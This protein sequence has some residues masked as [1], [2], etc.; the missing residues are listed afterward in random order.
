MPRAFLS[1]ADMTADR[2]LNVAAPKASTDGINRAWALGPFNTE[3]AA[4]GGAMR[5][6]Y[7]PVPIGVDTAYSAFP[8]VVQLPDGTLRMVYRQG[9]D[10]VATHDG[11]IK[12]CTSPDLGRTW[13]A[14]TTIE[15]DGTAPDVRDPS[16]SISPDGTKV[17]FTYFKENSSSVGIGMFFRLSTDG[18]ATYGSEV[19]MDASLVGGAITSPVVDPGTGTL[20]AVGYAKSGVETNYSTWLFTSTN[21]GTTWANARV[22]NGATDVRD[23]SEPWL[24]WTGGTNFTLAHRYGTAG[25][26]LR[27]STN[28]G[29]SWTAIAQIFAAYSGRPSLVK[30]ST[31]SLYM[32]LRLISDGSGWFAYSRDSGA[33]WYPPKRISLGPNN[34][35]AQTYACPIEISYGVAFVPTGLE[36]AYTSSL[37]RI[38]GLYI[39]DGPAMDPLGG[40]NPPTKLAIQDETDLIL[41]AD[42]FQRPDGAIGNPWQMLAGAVLISGGLLVSAAADNVPDFPYVD[43]RQGDCDISADMQWTGTQSGHGVVFRATDSSNY[44]LAT[45]ETA[46]ANLRIYKV[47]A[48]TATQLA[49]ATAVPDFAGRWTRYNVVSRGQWVWVTING[50]NILSYNLAGDYATFN[51][52]TSTKVGVKLN[53]QSGAAHFCRR[54]IVKA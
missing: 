46:G 25:V 26:S 2:V 53:A 40:L 10:H 4:G 16:I 24:I 17:Y 49:V 21:G 9:T 20:Y 8:G 7:P 5:A 44:L 28:S 11:V 19:R 14:P 3:S 15:S 30:L 37:S 18:G 43:I 48:G 42:D 22:S 52:A 31:G 32:T 27:T 33:T 41:F 13:T 12:T 47:V 54:F 23:Y 50:Q 1:G 45:Y 51:T 6:T 34:S 38:Y 39:T 29:T 36:Q 35:T